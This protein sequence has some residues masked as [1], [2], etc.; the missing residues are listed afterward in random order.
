ME[1]VVQPPADSE[2]HLLTV[3]GDA[4]DGPRRRRAVI[5]T[6]LFHVV[7]IAGL[8]LVPRSFFMLPHGLAPFMTP[9]IAPPAELTQK[10]P[11]NGKLNKKLDVIASRPRPSIHMPGSPP[12]IPPE[13]RQPAA[14]P[15]KALPEPPKIDAGIP[16]AN[17]PTLPQA[18]PQAPQIQQSEQKLAFETPKAL[19][20]PEPGAGRPL[21]R[22]SDV[23]RGAIPGGAATPVNIP[24]SPGLQPNAMQLLSD[25][26]GADFKPYLLAV[27]AT[28][29]RRWQLLYPRIGRDAKATILF[30]VGRSGEVIKLVFAPASGTAALDNAAIAAIS[31]AVPFPP[32]PKEYHGE[33]IRLQI[34]FNVR[35]R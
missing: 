14:P 18:Q 21:P 2:I 3:W 28:V 19:P 25:P 31:G 13:F 27:Q 30:S 11:N 32:F 17:L 7:A 6:V 4:S 34:D 20:A 1:T 8:A 29:S 15:P 22:A 24:P 16:K 26:M 33:E 9:L 35:E 23:I 12:G 5:G 10:E